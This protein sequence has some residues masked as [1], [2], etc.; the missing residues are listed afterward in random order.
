MKNI[1]FTADTHWFHDNIVKHCNRPWNIG[2][3]HNEA[4]IA[5][6]NETVKKGDTVY[7]LGDYAMIPAQK[8]GVP[9]MKLYRK[10]RMR[11]NG[12][13]ILIKGNHDQMSQDIYNECFT[14]VHILRDIKIDGEKIALCHYPMRSWNCSFHGSFHL[15]GHVHGRL[16]RVDTGVSCDVGIDVPEW[17]YRPVA[18][19]TLKP[20]LLKKR[21]IWNFY[22]L[23]NTP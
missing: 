3:E 9:R 18:W 23:K 6:W 4:L 13:I 2:E 10:L 12:K 5:N 15:F 22:F 8:D 17:N 11:L 19:D 1:F 7:L 16:E 20:K 14:E 21:E